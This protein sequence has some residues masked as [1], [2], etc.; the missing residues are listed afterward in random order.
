[1]FNAIHGSD[2]KDPS[3][4]TTP[5]NF[6]P[7]IK[8]ST[9]RIG[10]DPNAPPEMVAILRQLGM[11]STDIGPRPT[12]AGSGN[13]LGVEGAA[14]FDEYVQRKAKE[15]G[16]DLTALPEPTPGG[17]G[18]GGGGRGGAG[19]AAGT[20][21]NPMAAADWNP[22]FVNGRRGTAFDFVQ[23]QRRRY[24]LISKWAEFMKDL[25]MFIGAPSADVGVN[26]QTGH[27]CAVVPYK[28]D[29]P[30]QGFGGRGGGGGGAAGAAGAAAATTPPAPPP[31]PLNP[32]PICGTF[33][34]A[35]YNDD[36]ILSVAHQVR[37]HTDFQQKHPVL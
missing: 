24:I 3:T 20:P 11:Q 34:G 16:L 15:I 8:L 29:V 6:D 23:A 9:L 27:P 13:G 25:D 28:F 33:I 17:R 2:P 30:A 7:A 31:A 4:V 14:A 21:V 26:A 32:Q 5:F 22:R 36:K 19:G 1:V 12:V 18:G 37:L 10:V 35:L